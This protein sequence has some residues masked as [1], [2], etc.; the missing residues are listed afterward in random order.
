MG[1]ARKAPARANV[2][3]LAPPV[4]PSL[5]RLPRLHSILF[6]VPSNKHLDG[7][8]TTGARCLTARPP[9]SP[10]GRN[11]NVRPGPTGERTGRNNRVMAAGWLCQYL[12]IT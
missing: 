8:P 9:D 7:Y 2:D 12:G 6:L 5:W 4:L 3:R 1:R 10:N 11:R